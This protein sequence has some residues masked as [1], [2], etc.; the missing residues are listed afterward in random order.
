MTTDGTPNSPMLEAAFEQM[1]T[2]FIN[3]K[4]EECLDCAI[5]VYLLSKNI[6]FPKYNSTAR[7]FIKEC[8]QHIAAAA[9]N[10]LIQANLA[11]HQCSFCSKSTPEVRLGAGPSAFICNECVKVFAE[12]LS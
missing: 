2:E 3:E 4:Y 9:T 12:F 1:Q 10:S 5:V 8:S 11:P 6:E 7:H